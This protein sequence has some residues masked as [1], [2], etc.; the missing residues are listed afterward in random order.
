MKKTF[1]KALSVLL[2]LLMLLSVFGGLTIPALAAEPTDWA[3]SNSLPDAS[4]S[5]VLTSD[6]VLGATW[7]PV[8]GI[9]VDLNGHRITS[10]GSY[11]HFYRCSKR[12][13][14]YAERQQKGQYRSRR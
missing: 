2:S 13:N 4:G 3:S 9:T 14:L 6:I 8:D 1:K 11:D 10:G 5:Y 12:H 7:Y